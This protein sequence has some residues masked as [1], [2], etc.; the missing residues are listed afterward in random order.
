MTLAADVR[1]GDGCS[2]PPREGSH[3]RVFFSPGV[4]E[5]R[6]SDASRSARSGHRVLVHQGKAA[7]FL[8]L[9]RFEVSQATRLCKPDYPEVIWNYN[10]EEYNPCRDNIAMTPTC[11]KQAQNPKC[12]NKLE[13]RTSKPAV[14]VCSRP[15]KR[16]EETRQRKVQP[17]RLRKRLSS[18]AIE[19]IL[20]SDSEWDATGISDDITC[21]E[22]DEPTGIDVLGDKF[23]DVSGQWNQI[24]D[25]GQAFYRANVP[26]R[27]K[28][29]PPFYLDSELWSRVGRPGVA[30][31]LAWSTTGAKVMIVEVSKMEGT[32]ELILTGY[33]GRVMKESAKIALNWVRT[34]AIEYGI[35]L[36]RKIDLHIHFP[37]GAVVKDGPSAG[38]TI[39]TALMSLFANRPVAT[40]V[41]MTGEM[42]L[43]GMVVPVGGVR[44]KVLAA[45]RAGLKRVIL[46]RKCKMD[47]I[48]LADNVKATAVFLTERWERARHTAGIRECDRSHTSVVNRT[49]VQSDGRRPVPSLRQVVLCLHYGD[50]YSES[51]SETDVLPPDEYCISKEEGKCTPCWTPLVVINHLEFPSPTGTHTTCTLLRHTQIACRT[52][53]S[54]VEEH[55]EGS[56]SSSTCLLSVRD[57]VFYFV[58][59]V[60]D[61]LQAAF[62]GGFSAPTNQHSND[63]LASKL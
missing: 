44:D 38:I 36:D 52:T 63:Q 57:L 21:S 59:Y 3:V 37:M 23:A 15:H 30:V 53:L 7:P 42:T 54:I 24:D 39:A 60:D 29:S 13:A 5:K 25:V 26:E 18:G 16:V 27:E 28:R 56:S 51:G 40:D 10:S 19:M 41:A 48:E 58:D 43:T 14:T 61:V 45:H 22:E 33:L 6:P 8:D 55:K 34:A 11:F 4:Q 50:V 12:H 17:L 47:L 20:N 1:E 46:P 31:G 49:Q 9:V 62:E 32:G 35:K 2:N